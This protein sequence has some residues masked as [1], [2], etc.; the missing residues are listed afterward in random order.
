MKRLQFI[1]AV[2]M[3]IGVA[4]L[5]GCGSTDAKGSESITIAYQSSIGYA[6][7]LVMKEKKMIE[8]KYGGDITINWVEMKNGSAINEGMTSG[9]ID[10]GCMGVPVAVTGVMAGCPYKIAFGISAQPYS[11][12]TR[13]A[14]INSLSD[15]K[16]SDQIAITNINSQP[17]VLLAMAVKA[18]LG[19]AHALDKNLTV[20]GNADG[21]SAIVSGNVSCHMVISP[22]NFME[23]I[24]TDVDIHEISVDSSVWPDDN[25]ALVAVI[26]ENLKNKKPEVYDAI[27]AAVDEANAYIASNTRDAAEILAK[28][29]DA[30]PD[31]IVKWMTD[32]RS[33]YTSELHGVMRMVEF[34]VEEGFLEKGP[35]AITEIAYDTV[36]GE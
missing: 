26:T 6:P 11:I 31:E 33:V 9:S 20:L 28:G 16:D 15:I 19:D 23:Q 4:L 30:E 22:Y 27:L 36:K 24:S 35:S 7:I 17:H 3:C 8:E 25:T 1:F 2:L 12:M 5:G 34:M 29:Y 10:V 14:S 13:D 32:K 18:E 21:Y